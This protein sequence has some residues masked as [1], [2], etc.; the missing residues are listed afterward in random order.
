[1]E[2]K[3]H[4][5]KSYAVAGEVSR[6][7]GDLDQCSRD[8]QASY[9]PR[10]AIRK[11]AEEQLERPIQ[12]CVVGAGLAG[13]K[14]AQVL[15]DAGIDVTVFE[16]RDR[17]GGRVCQDSLAGRPVDMGPNWVHGTE[18]NPIVR[19]AS[20][21]GSRIS[22]LGEDAVYFGSDGRPVD[23]AR[24]EKLDEI[25][26][27]I[28]GEA[29][30]YSNKNCA[31]I[32]PELSLKDWLEDKLSRRSL[33]HEDI[34]LAMQMAQLWGSFIG[35]SWEKQSLKWF[36]LEECLDGGQ[37]NASLFDTVSAAAH[38]LHRSR[39]ESLRCRL[40]QA[41]HRPSS[42]ARPANRPAE[43]TGDGDIKWA[44]WRR[45]PNVM[46]DVYQRRQ[47]RGAAFRRG[48]RCDSHGL[49]KARRNELQPSLA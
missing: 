8:F 48:D 45:R 27:D 33:H 18:S 17:V 49:P 28:I 4:S 39:R 22:S 44:R 15:I 31:S 11:R 10:P 6:M 21:T 43:C 36:W 19:L 16:A 37:C 9:V 35:D 24:V 1:M 38:F 40:S 26:W 34:A 25:I 47:T 29:F 20:Q 30:A 42:S 3:T 5:S 41:Y 23:E 2:G 32:P 46:G 14:C 13:L 7:A 12:V